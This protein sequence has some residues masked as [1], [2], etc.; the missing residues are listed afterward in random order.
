M[1]LAKKHE[2]TGCMACVDACVHKVLGAEVDK[3]G[4]Y[5]I[6]VTDGDACVECGMC[7]R[8]CPVLEAPKMDICRPVPYAAWST[9]RPTRA[10]G[11]SGGL[12]GAMARTI[13]ADGGVVYG[14]AVDGFDVRHRRIESEADLHLLQGSKYQHSCTEGIFRQ[15]RSDLAKGR[16]V[17]FGGLSCQVAGLLKFLGRTPREN[18]LTVDTI[19][20][21]LSTML[22]M[23][24]LRDSGRYSGIVS[25]R[26]KENG[27]QSRGFRYALKMRLKDGGVE[28]LGL[29]NAVLNTFSSKLLKRSSCL[30]C[31]FNGRH[32]LADC[33]I[34]DFWGDSRFP[35]QHGGGLSALMVHTAKGEVLVSASDIERREVEWSDVES[36]NHNLIFTSY[37]LIRK[38]PWRKKALKAQ[39]EGDF[40]K[41]AKYM[42]TNTPQGLV[43]RVYLKLN[44]LIRRH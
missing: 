30:D 24:S 40:G 41:A 31:K 36:G 11:A 19:C 18:L 6:K 8:A 17:L 12:F 26:D 23:M 42:A 20:G 33:T 28:N 39:R 7:T 3:D 35:E 9:H 29:D 2:C 37:P 25:F 34:A 44:D 21:G 16:K 4:Y 22:P 1:R 27:W 32:R 38:F 13:L 43:L 14:A 15:V 10:Q 5:R